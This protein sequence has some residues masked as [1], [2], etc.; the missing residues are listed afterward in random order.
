MIKTSTYFSLL[1]EFGTAQ[2]PL[3]SMCRQYFCLSPAEAKRRA[4][5]CTLPIPTIRLATNKSPHIV[6]AECLANYIDEQLLK[7]KK[8]WNDVNR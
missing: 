1:A 7:A 6:K 3:E 5:R 4:S 2:I 8:Q